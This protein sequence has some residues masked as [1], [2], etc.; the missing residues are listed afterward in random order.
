MPIIDATHTTENS[1]QP[2]TPPRIY[3]VIGV[4]VPAIS[5]NIVL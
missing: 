3:K 5:K 1:I 4:Y 2:V